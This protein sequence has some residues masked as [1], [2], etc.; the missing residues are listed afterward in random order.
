MFFIVYID[1]QSARLRRQ[2]TI[3]SIIFGSRRDKEERAALV[4][5]LPLSI[6]LAQNLW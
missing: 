3:G 1:L 4:S 6:L 5:R 2:F